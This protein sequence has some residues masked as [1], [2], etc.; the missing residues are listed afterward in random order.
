MVD[1]IRV[2]DL[3]SLLGSIG[4]FL[5]ESFLFGGRHMGNGFLSFLVIETGTT[6]VPI[7]LYLTSLRIACTP[8]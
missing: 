3:D 5:F 7:S 2:A 1:F 4:A 8:R 6:I